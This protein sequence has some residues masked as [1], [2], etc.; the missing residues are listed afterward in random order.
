MKSKKLIISSI[1]TL[2][3]CGN[4]VSSYA[5]DNDVADVT[6]NLKVRSG[7]SVSSTHITTLS[8]G[9]DVVSGGTQQWESGVTRLWRSYAYP[10]LSNGKY[11]NSTRGW[12]CVRENSDSYVRSAVGAK[13]T[14]SSGGYLY[15]NS[16]LKD[17]YGTKYAQGQ[18]FGASNY[19]LEHSVNNMNAWAVS[20]GGQLKWMDG[21]LSNSY[22]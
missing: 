9:K 21:W 18:R 11:T 20:P 5:Y 19:R 10:L 12:L 15:K 4:I 16:S 3:V 22:Y 1:A 2:I 8:A 6:V 14:P 17:R 13:I 7:P